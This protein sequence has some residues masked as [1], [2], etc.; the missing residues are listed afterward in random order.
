MPDKAKMTT[1]ILYILSLL[2]TSSPFYFLRTNVATINPIE[3]NSK[4][5]LIEL[6]GLIYIK[7]K[8]AAKNKKRI[9]R[10]FFMF[11]FISQY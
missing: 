10:K 4:I 6:K 9:I 1:Y 3:L 2:I 11:I 5:L 7:I 8:L